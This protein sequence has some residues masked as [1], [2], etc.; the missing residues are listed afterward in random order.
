M[1][2][3]KAHPIS[4]IIYDQYGDPYDGFQYMIQHS[5]DPFLI[6]YRCLLKGGLAI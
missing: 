6:A 2:D 3:H 5:S 1:S 4:I